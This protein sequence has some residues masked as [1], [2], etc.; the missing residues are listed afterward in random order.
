V[1]DANK[2]SGKCGGKSIAKHL[3]FPYQAMR[4]MLLVVEL[5]SLLFAS[6]ESLESHANA[7]SSAG[8]VAVVEAFLRF[9]LVL[10]PNGISL[11]PDALNCSLVKI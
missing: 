7:H 2:E 1:E 11:A 10:S 9:L 6:V 3:N 5:F 4:K 8:L